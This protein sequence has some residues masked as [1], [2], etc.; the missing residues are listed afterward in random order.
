MADERTKE[1]KQSVFARVKKM[2]NKG[3]DLGYKPGKEGLRDR[4]RES[5]TS[6]NSIKKM[7]LKMMVSFLVFRQVINFATVCSV[8]FLFV[9]F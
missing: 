3:T 2:E 4:A 5:P 6:L 8:Y 9:F 7:G 1:K